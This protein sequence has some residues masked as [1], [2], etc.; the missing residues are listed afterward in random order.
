MRP[1]PD[2]DR[3]IGTSLDHVAELDVLTAPSAFAR[4]ASR[5]IVRSGLPVFAAV[6]AVNRSLAWPTWPTLLR[7]QPLA[8]VLRLGM[9]RLI[10]SLSLRDQLRS[11]RPAALRRK[12][13]YCSCRRLTVWFC[14]SPV[15]ARRH[16]PFMR[17]FVASAAA[18]SRR[19]RL[20]PYDRG[21]STTGPS[22]YRCRCAWTSA[23]ATSAL[24][25]FTSLRAS[26]RFLG[27]RGRFF[28]SSNFSI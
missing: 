23:L 12:L 10:S 22:G 15:K 17:C 24:N 11:L 7:P 1:A 25:R 19:N 27:F 16:Y 8:A 28:V 4:V 20:V 14:G 6:S 3:V 21:S 13:A 9:S 26:A 18:S 2:L 5:R